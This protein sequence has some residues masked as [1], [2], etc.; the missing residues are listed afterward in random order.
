MRIIR[1]ARTIADLEGSPDISVLHLS[2]AAG[3]RFLD[4]TRR[5]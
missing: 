1:I 2:E 3:F 5:P 4:K